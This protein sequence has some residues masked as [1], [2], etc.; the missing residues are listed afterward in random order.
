[1]P[2]FFDFKYFLPSNSNRLTISCSSSSTALATSDVGAL[3]DT[4]TVATVAFLSSFFGFLMLFVGVFPFVSQRPY[5]INNEYVFSRNLN[6][7]DK[8][9]YDDFVYVKFYTK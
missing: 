8:L 1:M 7:T 9:F 3:F 4:S 2:D 5:F 6:A